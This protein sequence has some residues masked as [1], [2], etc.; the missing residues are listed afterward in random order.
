MIHLKFTQEESDTLSAKGWYMEDNKGHKNFLRIRKY[1][2]KFVTYN[3]IDNGDGGYWV[4]DEIFI[5]VSDVT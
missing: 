1:A 2:D 4:E 5:K 3:W